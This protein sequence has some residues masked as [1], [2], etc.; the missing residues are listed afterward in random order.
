MILNA[1]TKATRL[2]VEKRKLKEPLKKI[3]SQIND[4]PIENDFL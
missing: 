2:R 1:I 4:M 3:I